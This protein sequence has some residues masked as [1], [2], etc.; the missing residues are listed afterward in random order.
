MARLMSVI[1]IDGISLQALSY[2]TLLEPFFVPHVGSF[3]WALSFVL[4]WLAILWI[5]Y[6][7]GI[8]LRV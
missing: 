4:I 1:R 5:L 8:A 7:R 6:R 2:R 3:L